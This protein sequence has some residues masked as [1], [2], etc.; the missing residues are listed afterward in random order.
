MCVEGH[1]YMKSR[2]SLYAYISCVVDTKLG[3][4]DDQELSCF[5]SK[6]QVFYHR[7]FVLDDLSLIFAF[8]VY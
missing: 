1:I 3:K 5:Y 6:P 4:T 2:S 8:L 7:S